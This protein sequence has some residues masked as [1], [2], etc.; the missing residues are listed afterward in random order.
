MIKMSGFF[1]RLEPEKIRKRNLQQGNIQFPLIFL[2]NL[3]LK[4]LLTGLFRAELLVELVDTES[5]H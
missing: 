3:N 2:A 5:E 1:C 4:Q